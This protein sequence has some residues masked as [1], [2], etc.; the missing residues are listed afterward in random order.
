MVAGRSESRLRVCEPHTHVPVTA[1]LF[2]RQ[3]IA[4]AEHPSDHCSKAIFIM[5]FPWLLL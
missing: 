2:Q 1:L 4:L 3:T 5:C